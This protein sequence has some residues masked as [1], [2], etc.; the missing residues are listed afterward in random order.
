MTAWFE[1]NEYTLTAA[2]N[3]NLMGTVTGG[4]VYEYGDTVTI[5]ATPAANCYFVRW[6]DSDTNA[7]RDVVVLGDA[8]YVAVFAYYPVSLTV[9]VN[10]ATMGTTTPAPGTYT[11]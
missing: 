8:S 11:Y 2:P 5:S 7:T 3:Y 9:A 1:T 4:G 10:D 6:S